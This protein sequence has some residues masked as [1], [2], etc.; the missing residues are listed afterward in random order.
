DELVE[1]LDDLLERCRLD[2]DHD[3]DPAEPLVVGGSDRERV[4]VVRPSREQVDD[5]GQHAGL[6]LDEDRERVVSDLAHCPP[7][8]V[9]GPPALTWN[10]G[11][12]T[13]VFDLPAGTIGKTF[14][15]A[16]VRNS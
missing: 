10:G 16:S 15:A 1:L 2:V 6:V 7:S 13:S 9:P 5:A 11:T 4:D 12:W 14:S 3:R 8:P